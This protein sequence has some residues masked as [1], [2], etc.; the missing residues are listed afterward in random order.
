MIKS[1]H[2]SRLTILKMIGT[3]SILLFMSAVLSAETPAPVT[4]ADRHKELKISC[5]GCHG[6]GEKKPVEMAQCFKCHT[7]YAAVAERTKDLTP[8][9][10][11]SHLPDLECNVCHLGHKPFVLYCKTCHPDMTITKGKSKP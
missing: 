4:N 7:S 2:I 3:F 5:E 9:P 6:S 10:H 8:N 11:S 1:R